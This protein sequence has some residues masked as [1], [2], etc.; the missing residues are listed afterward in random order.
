MS[1]LDIFGAALFVA[2]AA[3]YLLRA[4]FEAPTLLPYLL[5]L[6]ASF[7]GGWLSE[8]G[9]PALAVAMFIAGAFLLLHVA[10]QPYAGRGESENQR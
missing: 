3:M 4:R 10:S 6:L 5:I 1:M 9:A 8:F 7:A 2:T